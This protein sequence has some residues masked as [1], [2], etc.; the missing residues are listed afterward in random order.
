MFV[1]LAKMEVEAGKG[2][3]G[4]VAFR[5]EAYVPKGGPAGGDGGKGGDVIFEV[6][7]GLNTLSDYRH[8]YKFAAQSGEEGGKK[9]KHGKNGESITIKVPEGTVI[10]EAATGKIIADMSGDCMK[11]TVLNGGCGGL[12]NQ[13]FA[14]ATMQAPKY[15]QPGKPAKEMEAILELKLIAD[16]GLGG[17]P[18]VGKSSLLAR[19]SNARPEIADYHF[20][21]IRPNLGVVKVGEGASFVVADI[22]GLIEGASEG[23]LL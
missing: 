1:D 2:G 13:H 10:K 20:T 7:K 6:D 22:P 3:D 9:N 8:K 15:A 4:T 18:S 12:G 17:F 23:K 21:T 11:T 5:R 14:T 16:V 19:I